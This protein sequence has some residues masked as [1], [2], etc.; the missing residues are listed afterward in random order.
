M[1]RPMVKFVKNPHKPAIVALYEKITKTR[2]DD[3]AEDE[4][5]HGNGEDTKTVEQA[6]RDAVADE[7]AEPRHADDDGRRTGRDSCPVQQGRRPKNG[8]GQRAEAEKERHPQEQ[9]DECAPVLEQMPERRAA[10]MGLGAGKTRVRADRIGKHTRDD[11][12]DMLA[13]FPARHQK[14]HGFWCEREEQ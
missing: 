14:A 11:P 13:L 3:E 7:A 9:R 2:H 4:T 1:P 6:A 5:R 10:E 8:N 12:P